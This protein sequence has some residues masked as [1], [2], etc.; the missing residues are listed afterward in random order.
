MEDTI[1]LVEQAEP[2][3]REYMPGEIVLVRAEIE[4]RESTYVAPEFEPVCEADRQFA[5]ALNLE[6]VTDEIVHV[7]VA[8]AADPEPA[9]L[10]TGG[11]LFAE[12]S[13][14]AAFDADPDAPN[15]A[16]PRAASVGPAELAGDV[17]GRPPR[18]RRRR[19]GRGRGKPPD[20]R[21]G[22]E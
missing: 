9:P 16:G 11:H 13:G 19:G 17:G 18:R 14:P 5:A 3:E 2:V 10:P 22:S 6:I 20:L 1:D 4:E 21:Q 15:P 8:A 7:P 12:A